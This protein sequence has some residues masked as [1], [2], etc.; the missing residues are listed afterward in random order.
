MTNAGAPDLKALLA[1]SAGDTNAFL[2]REVFAKIRAD[3]PPALSAPIIYSYS[4]PGK[5]LRPALCLWSAGLIPDPI[6]PEAA[7]ADFTNL[8]LSDPDRAVFFASAAVEAI[9]TYSL[10][11]D[12]LPAMDDDDLRRGRPA[13]HIAYSEWAAILAGD[14]LNT[15]AFELLGHAARAA[16]APALLLELNAALSFGAGRM[17]SGQALD[18]ESERDEAADGD[19]LQAFSQDR[20]QAFSQDRLQ[21]IHR[22]KTAA[23]IRAA[24]E[25]GAILLIHR[26][27]DVTPEYRER[28]ARY[29]EELGLLF[30]I[31]DDILDV[32]GSSAELGKTA[33]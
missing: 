3:C 13:C 17:V 20:L 5:R 27:P 22:Q 2:E 10:I 32:E 6:A 18:L 11:H 4:A 28:L 29:G 9:H 31:V 30:H 26:E 12:A 15:L 23:L 8:D 21:A 33:G 16:N 1:R 19:R 24:L 7:A 14:A 25:L